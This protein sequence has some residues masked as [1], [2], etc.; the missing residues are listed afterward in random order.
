MLRQKCHCPAA[1]PVDFGPQAA[2]PAVA[3]CPV[4]AEP[5]RAG[6]PS[7]RSAGFRAWCAATALAERAAIAGRAA[8]LAKV[9]ATAP[10]RRPAHEAA[11]ARLCSADPEA[12]SCPTCPCSLSGHGVKPCLQDLHSGRLVDNG[13]LLF[14][15]DPA[16]RKHA[17]R[18]DRGQALV[19]E[20]NRHRR[21][22]VGE[23]VGIRDRDT[24]GRPLAVRECPW[25]SHD[26]LDHLV[27]GDESGQLIQVPVFALITREGNQRAGEDGGWIAQGD[28]DP[29]GSDIDP[30]PPATPGIALTGA[31]RASL[32]TQSSRPPRAVT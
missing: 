14:T 31:I 26:H 1:A 28:A 5:P 16:L 6:L 32:T 3:V 9:V 4:A 27:L 21:D 25:Q 2:A 19:G 13:T 7:R 10:A 15:L 11:C 8:G 29:D 30:K 23:L 12:P 24:R 22:L 17:R 20:P 18:S